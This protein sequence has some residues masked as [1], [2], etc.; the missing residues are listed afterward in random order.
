MLL[1]LP[2]AVYTF[3]AGVPA[4]VSLYSNNSLTLNLFNRMSVKYKLVLKKDLTKDAATDA[5]RYY[6]SAN[7]TG[8][9]DFDTICDVVADRS[10]AS[11]GDV[12]LVL[13]GLI[14]CMREAL[15]RGEVVQ[16]GALGNFRISLGSSGVVN[17]DDF[18]ASMIRKPRIIFSP[19]VKL[20]EMIAKVSVERIGL[21]ADTSGNQ[22]EEERPGEL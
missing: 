4:V 6:A 14:R 20:R 10:T 8:M 21:E 5:K 3:P 22:G 16:L 13:L 15:L 2:G 7:V 9:M 17:A 18:Q 1:K 12:A 19:G 11:D